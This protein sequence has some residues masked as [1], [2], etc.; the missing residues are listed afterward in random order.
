MKST[1]SFTLITT[2]ILW[3]NP[4]PIDNVL[5]QLSVTCKQSLLSIV[6]DIEPCLP[7]GQIWSQANSIAL[8]GYDISK[9]EQYS[10]LLDTICSAPRCDKSTTDTLSTKIQTDC[11]KDS[12][13]VVIQALEY[14]LKNYEPIVAIGCTRNSQQQYC[15]IVEGDELKD[16]QDVD[17]QDIPNEKLC[18][19]CV[20][21]WVKMYN[22]Y[23]KSYGEFFANGTDISQVK[24][25]CGY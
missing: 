11:S 13:Q 18:T 9:V 7:F 14:M 22:Q 10:S 25:K 20:Q 23:S 3:V 19:E 16:H 6:T 1:L 8:D 17:L 21:N 5:G 2:S 24:E 15:L 12:S 4:A